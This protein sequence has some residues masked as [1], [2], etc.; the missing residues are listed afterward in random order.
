MIILL[1]RL[2]YLDDEG[3][4]YSKDFTT[5]ISYPSASSVVSEFYIPSNVT[6]IA[7]WAFYGTGSLEAIVIHN[8]VTAIGENAFGACYSATLVC[9]FANKPQG[10]DENYNPNNRPVEWKR[11][12]AVNT[13]DDVITV[14]NTEDIVTTQDE[15]ISTDTE[16]VIDISVGELE[17]SLNKNGNAYAV[18]SRNTY[19]SCDVVIPCSYSGLPVTSVGKWS[20]KGSDIKSVEIPES[21]TFI[22]D[23]AFI[24]CC[25]LE[26]VS[27][28]DG[29]KYI[30][31][32]SFCNCTALKSLF[33]PD[34][35]KQIS[36]WAFKGCTALT[37]VSV[38]DTAELD[39]KAFDDCPSVRIVYRQSNPTAE[40]ITIDDE[41][42][43]DEPSLDDILDGIV[44]DDVVIDSIPVDMDM[45]NR[46][47][48]DESFL[49]G[50][51]IDDDEEEETNTDGQ[52]LEF[53][54]NK[55][56][57]GYAVK[58]LGTCTGGTITIPEA[59]NG[60]PVTSI[61]KGAF[62]NSGIKTVFIPSSV[63]FI[64]EKAF[65]NCK[66]L[67]LVGLAEG[68]KY[69]NAGAFC[70][71]ES[72]SSI[73]FPSTLKSVGFWAFRNCTSL[74]NKHLPSG[75]SVDPSAFENVSYN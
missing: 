75:V 47:L 48:N 63:M 17:F 38:P 12:E 56:G 74:T 53:S 33:F 15:I 59:Y 65:M 23:K 50:I 58:G 42:T 32:G 9:D 60:L 3:V 28:A 45:V 40:E 67:K 31:M 44:I 22:G 20:F 30:N 24:D 4:L 11:A 51:G 52:E 68:L 1:L 13:I 70:D 8:G 6:S 2:L 39:E 61:M 21:V 62:K 55:K 57:D 72:L 10:W 36:F 66:S 64:D 69:I 25:Q 46:I 14:V 18:K 73:S 41:I 37:E 54:L 27:F 26:S 19:N 71:C 35:L 49:D 43:I 5:L 34:S 7:P 16:T 29:I